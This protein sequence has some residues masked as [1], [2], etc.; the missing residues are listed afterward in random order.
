MK[1]EKSRKSDGPKARKKTT[2]CQEIG[3]RM[4]GNGKSG[5]PLDWPRCC[6]W[7]ATQPRSGKADKN[8]RVSGQ[9]RVGP[10]IENPK[11]LRFAIY[12]PK[13]NVG[14]A[15]GLALRA[16]GW[17]M[18]HTGAGALT[19]SRRARSDAPYLAGLSALWA[20]KNW[21]VE[22]RKIQKD[23]KEN[24]YFLE[25]CGLFGAVGGRSRSA[26]CRR[27]AAGGLGWS[28]ELSKTPLQAVRCELRQLAVRG[29][30]VPRGSDAA[31]SGLETFCASEIWQ[32]AKFNRQDACSTHGSGD[33]WQ[34]ADDK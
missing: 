28:Y 34:M 32:D 33:R 5:R 13:P 17:S 25:A 18:I 20:G 21:R 11:N 7:S 22:Q 27:Q 26:E 23:T 1:M 8:C 2:M 6:G 29:H 14:L 12:E 31:P 19:C 16:H 10:T 24:V 9:V 4:T 15:T 3:D 30:I